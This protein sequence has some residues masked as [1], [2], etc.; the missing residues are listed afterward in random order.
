MSGFQKQVSY[1][2]APGVLGD[3]A[4]TNPRA[5]VISGPGSIIAGSAGVLAGRFVWLSYQFIDGDEAPAVAN[6]FGSGA[7]AGF[8]GRE[9]QGLIQNYLQEFSMSIPAG[10]PVTPY[11]EGDFWML[12]SGSSYAQPGQKV[13]ANFADGNTTAA[14]SGSPTNATGSASSIAA[15]TSSVTGSITDNLLTVT[16]V[17]SGTVVPGTTISGTNVTSG[18]QIVGQVTPLLSGET[19]GGVGRYYVS[20][21]EQTVASTTISGT[22]GTLT[23]G[24]TVAGT[25]A[26]GQTISG[27]NVV[28]GTAITALGTGTGGAGTYIVN[29]NTVVSSTAITAATNYETKWF[30]RSGA[31]AGEI[32]KASSWPQG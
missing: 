2:L 27:T 1:N 26:V 10:F 8:V 5:S 16:A 7:V 19:T 14:A 17:G 3:F 23:V 28:A 24:G 13:Y 9:Q 15:S 20:I 29:N 22:Y 12:N 4:T 25:W 30:V 6:N 21:G 11:S 32:F 31:A 18:T